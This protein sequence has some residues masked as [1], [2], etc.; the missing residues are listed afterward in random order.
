M[1]ICFIT[2][3]YPQVG[4]AHGGIGSFVQTLARELLKSGI[5][6][7]VVG[8]GDTET[9]IVDHDGLITIHR[10]SKSRWKFARFIDNS[11]KI[12]GTLELIDAQNKIDIIET[13]E[14]GQAFISV[15][16][17][18][19]RIIRMHGGHHFFAHT[20]GKKTHCWR[21]WQEKRSF[22]NAD[23][24]CAVSR[25]V[26][27]TTVSLLNLKQNV[28]VIYNPIDVS[29]FY[30]SNPLQVQKRKLL[31]IGTVC[32]KKGIKQLLKAMC[33][34]VKQYPD[35]ELDMVGRDWSSVECPSY[36]EYLKKNVLYKDW[37]RNIHFWGNIS[38]DELPA[39]IESAE[40][41]VFPSLMESW[42]IVVLEGMAMGK[43]VIF[44]SFGPG[45]EIV[46]NNVTG[47]L[48]NTYNPEEIAEKIIYALENPDEM[49]KM[50]EAARKDV[51][52][53]FDVS[54]LVKQNIEFYQHCIADK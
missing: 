7:T 19:K 29:K 8:L 49:H 31:F 39:L 42:G 2:S 3:E 24:I 48:C 21:A 20:L 27:T 15:S 18:V 50:G 51:L 26:A 44:M 13:A 43:P 22:A 1:H 5:N 40:L 16:F 28:E 46:E 47:M 45:P 41:C 4:N 52:E 17:P 9:S 12:N 34:V 36:I 54:V 23:C 53:R 37:E 10:L 25:Y 11:R 30:E 14:L 38:H 33:H 35:V 32:E 6:V